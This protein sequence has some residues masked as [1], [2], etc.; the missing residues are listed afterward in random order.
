[1][2]PP[3]KRFLSRLADIVRRDHV[4]LLL[5]ALAAASVIGLAVLNVRAPAGTPTAGPS[6]AAAPSF[7]YV[8]TWNLLELQRHIAAGEVAAISAVPLTSPLPGSAGSA[9]TLVARLT[10]G[11]LVQVS[12]DVSAGD[13]VTALRSLGYAS[14]LTEEALS[15]GRTS[16]PSNGSGSG[17][18]VGQL[19]AV[20]LVG[21]VLM[22]GLRF[23]VRRLGPP[24]PAVTTATGF[25]IIEPPS[26]LDDPATPKTPPVRMNDVAGIEEAKREVQEVVDFL[27]KPER[28][29][30]LG[31]KIPRGLLFYGPPGTGKTMLARAIAGEAGVRFISAS[32]AQF[33]EMYVGVGPKRVRELFAEARKTPTC[34]VFIDELDAL[35]A[36]R[37]GP[38]QH[39]EDTKT[40]NELLTQLDGFR[41]TDGVVVVG[42]TNRLDILDEAAIRPGR[43][44]RK[45]HVPLPDRI[46]RRAILDVHARNKPLA[47]DADLDTIATN[48]TGMSG[49]DLAEMLNE[50]A[51]L[52]ARRGAE[53]ISAEDLRAGW[54]KVAMG[55]GR[56]RSMPDRER[57]VIAAHEA[58]HAVCGR[59]HG[60]KTKVAEV[61]LFAHG[62]ADGEALGF[63]LSIPE[64]NA[65]PSESDLRADLVALMGGRAAEQ[66]LFG[67]STPGA[68]NDFAKANRIATAMVTIWGMGHDPD[69]VDAGHHGRGR[70]LSLRIRDRDNQVS[71]V[72]TE[73]M[74]RA[75][76]TILDTSYERAQET[77][78]AEMER[79]SRVAAYLFEHERMDGDDFERVFSGAE[80]VSAQS[81]ARWREGGLRPKLEIPPL[82]PTEPG[83]GDSA[84]P[85]PSTRRRR[86]LPGLKRPRRAVGGVV[87]SIAAHI[88]GDRRRNRVGG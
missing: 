43:F 42:A 81:I 30:R 28:F 2:P 35:A 75:I 8:G 13:A 7:T 63:T 52:A 66:E 54:L 50:S 23:L 47:P 73:A 51:I 84:Q 68:S 18:D 27:R 1:M 78:R 29:I 20:L 80:G 87:A 71:Q 41:T 82:P 11:D 69:A 56:S 36:R 60:S 15:A 12:L 58:G 45:I 31:A 32:G 46:A 49:A 3:R 55:T 88:I 61:S 48:T 16:T 65:L 24:V 38:N 76:L 59:V 53:T 79:L 57:S 26:E 34:I 21:T 62:M 37:G 64:D 10:S 19:M 5:V 44:S 4:S 25:Q 40:L 86:L 67:E 22:L 39:S 72:T 33:S 74:E 14:L 9:P 6:G 77:V 17:F 85:G 83:T 70:R